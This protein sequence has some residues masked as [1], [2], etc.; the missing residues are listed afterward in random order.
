VANSKN[1]RYDMN[2]VIKKLIKAAPPPPPRPAQ[3]PVQPHFR[4][5]TQDTWKV[6]IPK[7]KKQRPRAKPSYA[8]PQPHE[9]NTMRLFVT[10]TLQE[11]A[12]LAR[13]AHG[14]GVSQATIVRLAIRRFLRTREAA[15][16]PQAQTLWDA[17]IRR[18]VKSISSHAAYAYAVALLRDAGDRERPLSRKHLE[19]KLAEY[20]SAQPIKR[21]RRTLHGPTGRTRKPGNPQGYNGTT[22][23]RDPVAAAGDRVPVDRAGVPGPADPPVPTP[24]KRLMVRPKPTP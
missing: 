23:R 15:L 8:T 5:M 3:P 17:A 22:H 6:Q 16:L 12:D 9:R 18:D 7:I 11:K 20:L 4:P 13:A 24:T 14:L 10:M 21:W 19:Q 1:A 2:K